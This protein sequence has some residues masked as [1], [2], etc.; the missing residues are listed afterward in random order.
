M[1]KVRRFAALHQA[2]IDSLHRIERA[3]VLGAFH[4]SK[5]R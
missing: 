3:N 2:A 5:K 1:M 4:L